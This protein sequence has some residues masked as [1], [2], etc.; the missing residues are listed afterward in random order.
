MRSSGTSEKYAPFFSQSLSFS[1][2]RQ[3]GDDSVIWADRIAIGFFALFML[4]MNVIMFVENNDANNRHDLAMKDHLKTEENCIELSKRVGP[5][6]KPETMSAD[7]YFQ[8]LICKNNNVEP[9]T[10]SAQSNK[11]SEDLSLLKIAAAYALVFGLYS[12]F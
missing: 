12:E 3:V 10:E 5:N 9:A 8:N 11:L 7:D 6:P 2:G 4:G 1:F